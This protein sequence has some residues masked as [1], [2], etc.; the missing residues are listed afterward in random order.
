MRIKLASNQ[1]TKKTDNREKEYGTEERMRMRIHT[2][3][4][5]LHRTTTAVNTFFGFWAEQQT[6]QKNRR[7]REEKTDNT[8]ILTI[9]FRSTAVCR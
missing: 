8:N 3:S 7:E 2:I 1:S 4:F 5:P 9:G 6:T